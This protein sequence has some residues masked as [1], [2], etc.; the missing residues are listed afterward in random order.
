[1][2]RPACRS[3]ITIA[4]GQMFWRETGDGP[5]LVLLHGGWSD[6]TQWRSICPELSQSFRCYLP[7]LPGFG[8]SQLNPGQT[9]SVALYVEALDQFLTA[10]NLKH[11]YL[12]GYA[13]GSWIAASY[14]LRFPHKVDRIILIE[15]EG[16]LAP[17]QAW[18]CRWGRRLAAPTSTWAGLLETMAPLGD[19]PGPFGQIKQL[20]VLRRQIMAS[21]LAGALL[22]SRNPKQIQQEMLDPALPYLQP[23]TFLLQ[24]SNAPERARLLSERYAALCY[25]ASVQVIPSSSSPQ[26]QAKLIAGYLKLF[27]HQDRPRTPVTQPLAQPMLHPVPAARPTIRQRLAQAPGLSPVSSPPAALQSM[28]QIPQ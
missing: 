9:L 22:Y 15:P 1:M 8:D 13:L 27:I 24:R 20:L 7:D 23:P 21:P 28:A 4:Q 16:V 10:I 6:S 14:A 3:R 19:L 17:D 11:F 26:K 12:V 5:P 2:F 18:L 25:N